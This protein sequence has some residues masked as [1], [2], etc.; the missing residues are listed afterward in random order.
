MKLKHLS[1]HK[2]ALAAAGFTIAAVAQIIAAPQANA[3]FSTV[4]VRFDRL[5]ISTTTTGVVCANP[6]T[7]GTEAKVQVAFPTGYSVSTTLANWA[8]NTS[9]NGWPT[10]AVAWPGIATAT[11]ATGQTVTFPSGDLTVG[12]LYCFNWTNSNAIT[13]AS[14]AASTQSG[15]VTSQ[16]SANALIDQSGYATATITNDQI[17]VTASVPQS[18]AFALSGNTDPISTTL[19][20]ATVASSTTPRTATVNTNAKAG[21]SVWATDSNVGLKSASSGNYVI[22]STT[23]GTNSTLTAGNEGYNMG[24]TSTQTGGSGTISIAA[25]FTAGATGKGGGLDTT[26]RT[27]ATSNGTASGGTLTMTNNVAISAITPAATDYND[28]ITVVGAGLF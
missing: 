11:A 12:T 16:T 15:T 17:V 26:Y 18:F 27:L 13:T 2:Y 25:P 8:V 28:T 3:V 5:Q 4:L 22:G 19:S 10:G 23:P 24:V 1:S 14:T 9:N 20:T 21:W 7:T 6:A